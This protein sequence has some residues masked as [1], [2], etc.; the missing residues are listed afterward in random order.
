MSGPGVATLAA[1]SLDAGY[2]RALRIV[3]EADVEVRSGEL[4]ALLGANGAGKTTVLRTLAGELAPLGGEIHL[5]GEVASDAAHLRARRGVAYV[6]DERSVLMRLTVL[7]NF[8]VSR[9][10]T[11]EALRM[12]PEL[13][14]HVDRRVG[15]L[16][17]GQQQILALAIA[18]ARK[19][20]VIL[21]DELSLGLAPLVVNR[22]LQALR[23]AADDGVAVLLVEQ[24]IHKALDVADRAY[25]MQRGVV[26]MSGAAA[27]LA[28]RVKDIQG[29]YL[30]VGVARGAL[31]RR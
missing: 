5:F 23:L 4:V 7:E 29:A 22:L 20:K 13:E 9:C 19:P 1:R 31:P 16:S 11:D 15:L 12:F 26:R 28:G 27:E 10:D 8:R 17:G 18:L 24:H 6:T 3:R 21:A 14:P 25:V 2:G 30:S